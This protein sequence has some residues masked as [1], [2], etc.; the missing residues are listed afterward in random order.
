MRKSLKNLFFH[1]DFFQRIF[2]GFVLEILL[3]VSRETLSRIIKAIYI[4]I[5]LRTPSEIQGFHQCIFPKA[6]ERIRLFFSG[7][8]TEILA[9]FFQ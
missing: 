3:A 8:S 1:L 7:I 4:G 6:K 9:Y 2:Q 5:L